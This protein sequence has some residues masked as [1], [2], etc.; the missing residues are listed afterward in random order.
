MKT[1]DDLKKLLQQIDKRPYPAYKGLKGEYDFKSYILS[2]DHVQ[3]DPF[4]APSK[5]SVIVSKKFSKLPADTYDTRCKRIAMQDFLLRGMGHEISKRS[6]IAKG[7]GKSGLLSISRCTEV[8][9][10]KSACRIENGDI[11]IKMEAGFPANGRTINSYELGKILFDLLPDI[12]HNALFYENL[13]KAEI[14]KRLELI[15]NQ[16]HIREELVKRGLVAFVADGSILPRE[17]G[18]SQ[19]PL[20]TAVAFSSPQSLRVDIEIPF[21]GK[22]SG[23]GLRKGIT[24]IVGGGYHGKSTLLDAIQRG[25]Y[26]HIPKDGREYVITD[27]SA[28]KIKAEDGRSIRG[29]DISRFIKNLPNGTDTEFFST[30]NASGSTSQAAAVSE[31]IEA[32]ARLLLVDED[33]CATNFMV[34]DELMQMVISREK[35]PISPYIEHMRGLSREYDMSTVMVAG[36][37]G[38]FFETADTIIQMNCYEAADIT[39]F[40]K[41]KLAEYKKQINISNFSTD[42]AENAGKSKHEKDMSRIAIPENFSQRD[43]KKDSAR[44]S[45]ERI[46]V[47]V[48]MCDSVSI[49]RAEI[50]LRNVEQLID[51]E[52]LETLA[53]MYIYMMT[54]LADKKTAIPILVDKIWELYEKKG[55]DFLKNPGTPMAEIRKQDIFLFINR[56]RSLGLTQSK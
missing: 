15:Q 26:N 4:A 28:V 31:A 9:C 25:I 49:N 21:G 34:R 30:E 39:E 11:K 48:N 53:H 40:A 1:S 7:S 19:R 38:A 33:T 54:V 55:F 29:V 2:I 50:D 5:I 22:I 35:E 45:S 24:L 6:F 46:K 13:D 16:E 18:V 12:V 8:V 41:E 43:S 27:R 52:Q 17:S 56:S 32:G 36:S 23:M 20:K 10:D 47:R 51:P 37:S 3:G 14:K 42:S 44:E